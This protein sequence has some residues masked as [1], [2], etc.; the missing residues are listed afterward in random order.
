MVAP[1]FKQPCC[2]WLPL[3]SNSLVAFGCPLVQTALLLLVAPWFKQPCGGVCV[4][5]SV[6]DTLC[7]NSLVAGCVEQSVLDTLCSNS[8]VVGC[9][10]SGQCWTPS[11]QTA[12]WWGVCGVISV[13]HPLFKQPCDGRCA[14]V[15]V[16][17]LLFKQP[18]GGVWSG[19][20]WML[21]GQCF[22]DWCAWFAGFTSRLLGPDLS[23][24]L[25]GTVF[26]QPR[27]V[28]HCVSVTG[29]W[30]RQSAVLSVGRVECCVAEQRS[31]DPKGGR[32]V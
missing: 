12:L 22:A 5:W 17:H 13:G 30:V 25:L 3:G 15:S 27:F 16:G 28:W 2:F 6:L 10:W 23:R 9:V 26:S 32:T 20:C 4:E 7:S 8:L 31:P 14:A 19:Q 18:C 29:Q 24:I 1:W 21:V 11:V